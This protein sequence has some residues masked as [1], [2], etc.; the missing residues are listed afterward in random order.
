MTQLIK[1]LASYKVWQD[2]YCKNN[3]T[4]EQNIERVANYIFKDNPNWQY[5]LQQTML[6][7][8]FFPAGRTMSN[9]GIGQNLTLNN[10]FV[11]NHVEDSMEEIFEKVKYGALTQKAGGGTGYDFS[12]IR[13]KGSPTSNDA[14][15]SGVVSFIEAFDSQTKTVLQ[16]NRRK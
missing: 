3:E 11:L 8:R 15:A 14:V 10:C 16:G 9:A 13:P 4:I 12:K 5:S 7:K 1:N 2:R 6:Q